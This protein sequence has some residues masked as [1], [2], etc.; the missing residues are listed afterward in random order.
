MTAAARRTVDER[1]SS[2]TGY[3]FPPNYAEIDGLRLH[4]VDVGSGRPIVLFHGEPTW[5]F[6]YRKVIPPLVAAGYRAV[7][8]DFAGF[9]RSD[10]PTDP[11]FYTYDAHVDLMASLLG[12]LDVEDA[13]AVVHDWGGP[14][15]LR[16]VV[17]HPEWFNR[18]VVM[19]TDLFSGG[20]ASDGFMAWRRFVERTPDL[21]VRRIM[22][23][24]MATDWSAT[25]LDGYEAP[26]PTTEH[27]VGAHRFPLMV[28]L[29]PDEPGAAEMCRVKQALAHWPHPALVLFST[30]DPI[31]PV[32]VG[33]RWVER[34]PGA[35]PLE[36][37]EEAGHFLQEDAGDRV[38]EHIA[39]FLRRTD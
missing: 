19:N 30:N 29:S 35:H 15:G 18:L 23:R 13:T 8:P 33:E 1:F 12:R 24:A 25:T 3:P 37:V 17:D 11:A 31:F 2:L 32:R 27:K 5:S 4:Y 16:L 26:F 9:G 14:I 28:P 21:P 39:D 6:L 34:L 20:G 10:K 7:A 36:L 38:A 22:E